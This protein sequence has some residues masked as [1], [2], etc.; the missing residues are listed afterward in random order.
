[1]TKSSPGK[2]LKRKVDFRME[3]KKGENKKKEAKTIKKKKKKLE[4]EKGKKAEERGGEKG[5]TQIWVLSH[6]F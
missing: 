4:T 1:M 3:K 5:K 2:V 6:V